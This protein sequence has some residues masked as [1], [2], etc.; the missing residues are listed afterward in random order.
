LKIAYVANSIIPSRT[1]NSIHVMKMCAAFARAGHDVTLLVPGRPERAKDVGDAFGYYGVRES[2][3]VVALPWGRVTGKAYLFAWRAARAARA[4]GADLCYGRMVHACYFAARAGLPVKFESHA[5]VTDFDAVGAW[6]F[7]RLLR[8]PRFRGLVVISDALRRHYEAGYGAPGRAI[9]VA[10]DAADEA[11][12]PA[13]ARGGDR[14]KVG[15]VGHLYRGRGIELIVRL[16]ERCP[17][18]EFHVVGGLPEDIEVWRGRCRSVGNL[19]FHGFCPPSDVRSRIAEFDVV[20]APYQR[21]VTTYGER[22][23]TSQWMSPLK[24]FEYMAAAKPMV[25]SDLPVLREVL[26]DSNAVLVDPESVDAWAEAIGR[27]RDPGLR[28]R[29]G[30]GAHRD[31]LASHTWEQR[32]RRVLA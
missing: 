9:V 22:H 18:A 31:F 32:A 30:S 8:H 11:P 25:A 27:L 19:R 15:Y 13:A 5:P 14:L 23:D 2:F 4:S 7:R 26:N 28:G 29:I 3:R 6:M 1:A 17:W 16:A 21:A 20:L 10:P 24:I 12:V